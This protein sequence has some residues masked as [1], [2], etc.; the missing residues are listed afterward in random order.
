MATR[1]ITITV[2]EELVESIKGR[3]DSR[4]VSAYIAA[5]AAHQDEMDRLRELADRLEEEHGPVTDDDYQ[6]ALDRI[7]EMDAWHD[8][9]KQEPHRS[10]A[11]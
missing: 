7:A 9:Q 1:K 10:E 5:A 11:A 8:G 6:A 2:P 4:G 3:V